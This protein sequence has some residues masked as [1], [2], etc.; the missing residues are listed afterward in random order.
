MIRRL[1]PHPLS[2]FALMLVWVLLLNDFG[3]GMLLFGFLLGSIVPLVTSRFWPNRPHL[4]RPWLLPEYAAVVIKDIVLANIQ[5]ARIVLFKNNRDL[6]PAFMAIPLAIETPEAITILAWTITL[7]PGTLSADL[8]A[9]GKVL[10]IHGLD[11]PDVPGT[12]ADIKSRYEARLRE[13]F[14]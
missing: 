7:T 1:F 10:L 8:S 12:I 9:D 13:I 5:V 4:R 2:T 6:R 14:A 3:T 11:V